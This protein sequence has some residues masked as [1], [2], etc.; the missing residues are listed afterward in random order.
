M[1]YATKFRI[2]QIAVSVLV[3]IAAVLAYLPKQWA[4]RF[5]LDTELMIGIL[6]VL[7]VLALF[8][9]ARFSY[10]LLTVLLIA[11]ANL[12][13]R[14]AQGL[15]ID[16]LPLLVALGVMI[17]ISLL[18]RLAKF[19][20]TGL[21][22]KPKS[23]NPDGVQA[24]MTAVGRGQEHAVRTLIKMNIDVNAV[25]DMGRTPLMVAAAAGHGKMVQFLIENGADV[26]IKS[27]DGLTAMSI[28]TQFGQ[29]D[30]TESIQAALVKK[31]GTPAPEEHRAGWRER[32]RRTWL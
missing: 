7:I 4:E 1:D 25:D 17:A 22:P 28:A 5:H 23:R 6:G 16:R 32:D 26:E 15:H 21:E 11:G 10:F 14:W 13:D 19:L 29:V 30:A 2:K 12:P 8:V 31:T 3:A 18:N 27:P 24:L 20:P 9:F